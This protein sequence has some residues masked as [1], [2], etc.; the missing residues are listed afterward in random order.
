M[1]MLSALFFIVVVVVDV[2]DVVAVVLGFGRCLFF[3]AFYRAI[4][5]C[6]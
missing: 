5:N 3:F 6:T 4:S 1:K 2:V